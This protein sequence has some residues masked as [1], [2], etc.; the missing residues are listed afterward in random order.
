VKVT[1]TWL[2][3]EIAKNRGKRR[4]RRTVDRGA[5]RK[6]SLMVTVY[7]NG[8]AAFSV[9]YTRPDGTR[10]FMPL[11]AFGDAGL[12]LADAADAHDEALKLLA[13]HID[14]IEEQQ[15]RQAEAERM[16]L[17]RA[18]ADSVANIVEEFVH[19]Q[20]R[21][22]EWDERS[23][24]WVREGKA[25]TKTRK[26]PDQAAAL[27]GYFDPN[28]PR[29]KRKDKRKNVR[30]LISEL[31]HKKA[32]DVTRRDLVALLDGIVDRGA[33]ITANRVHA[34]L[35]QMWN[36]AVAR[37][38][39]AMSPMYGVPRPISTE[40]RRA[41]VLTAAEVRTFWTKL[42]TADMAEP[43]R[44]A[45]K[46][47]LATAQ[48]RGEITQARWDHFDLDGKTWTI[49][50]ELLKSSH[51]RRENP[52]S[53]QVPLSAL[54]LEL[55]SKLKTLTGDGTY[56]LPARA[57]KRS[58]DPY[59]EGVLSRA[60]R[61]NAKHFGLKERFTPHDLRRTAASFMTKLKVPRLHVEKVLNHSAGDIAEVYDRHDYLRE[62][63]AA[64]EL[65]GEHLAAIL[66]GR[67]REHLV[68]ILESREPRG[69]P[70][71]HPQRLRA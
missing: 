41:R 3:T 32:R 67:E 51:T 34:L 57:D 9:R 70:A 24:R 46:L 28:K 16:R 53:H 64:L 26:C 66:E 50:V 71:D 23:R 4:F 27:L 13:K 68:E 60:A 38:I 69:V 42:S 12:S 29:G 55:L 58:D 54:A 35:V 40:K 31:G 56:V 18:G 36:W 14:P 19:R 21:G 65:W 15:R 22:E 2:R 6:G 30:T 7:G 47:L 44:L 63:R 8:T 25:S 17:E 49:P 61:A 62:K 1:D 11:G 43:T 33:P 45:L 37:E 59:S 20:L 5:G 52:E 39:I 10:V 48:R